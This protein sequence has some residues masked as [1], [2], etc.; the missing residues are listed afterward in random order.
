M[1]PS[2]TLSPKYLVIYCSGT[3][4]RRIV[5][6]ICRFIWLLIWHSNTGRWILVAL[7]VDRLITGQPSATIFPTL[8]NRWERGYTSARRGSDLTYTCCRYMHR[9]AEECDETL[10]NATKQNAIFIRYRYY[11]STRC[12]RLDLSRP[13]RQTPLS[14][15]STPRLA[16]D[17]KPPT[18]WYHM[19]PAAHDS[20]YYRDTVQPM[21]RG[22]SHTTQPVVCG[23]SYSVQVW[24]VSLPVREQ[25]KPEVSSSMDAHDSATRPLY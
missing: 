13:T 5:L 24:S 11:L 4:N 8:G 3:R 2:L 18:T 22:T 19:Y 20:Q 6:L 1:T 7:V 15:D 14:L 21:V 10:N 16:A 23:L 25:S 12:T 17:M 9:S